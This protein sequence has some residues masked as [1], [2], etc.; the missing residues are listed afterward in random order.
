METCQNSVRIESIKDFI[1]HFE[2]QHF[3]VFIIGSSFPED[4]DIFL[5]LYVSGRGRLFDGQR[6]VKQEL[7]SWTDNFGLFTS[8]ETIGI[9]QVEKMSSSLQEFIISYAHHPNPHLTLFLFTSK[10]EFFSAFSSKLPNALCLSLFGEYFA[11]R[12]SRIAQVLIK[13]SMDVQLSCSLGVA[14]L[15]V[16]KFPQVGVFEIFSEFQKLICQI[17][18]KSCLE[19][20]DVQSFVEK[21]ESASLWKLRDAL[22]RRDLSTGQ[23]LMQS[24]VSDLGEDPLAILNFL[25]SQYLSGLRAIAEQSKDRKTQIFFA[26]GEQALLNGLNLFFHAESLIKNNVQDPILSLET[27]IARL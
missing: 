12:D 10:A 22:L 6:L 26:A 1:H 16:S 5:E 23:S 4:K 20:S 18:G 2:N 9:Y 11:E 3:K 25:R 14:K 7:L 15:F 27:M 21:R 24:L 13:R 19:A 17:G 8:K